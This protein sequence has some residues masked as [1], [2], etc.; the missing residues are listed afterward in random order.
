MNRLL[1][2]VNIPRFF[3]SHRLPLALA[4]RDAGYDVHVA[5]SAYDDSGY[6]ERIV[7]AGFPFHPLPLH[8]HSTSPRHELNTL[9]AITRLY[10][11]LQ[12]D[13][14]HHVTVKSILYGGIAARI[15]GVP[16]VV[17][18]VSGLGY[19]FVAS[20]AKAGVIRWGVK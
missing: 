20:G 7:E 17:N 6:M 15:S 19:V 2:L 4:A 3:V 11:R 12:P 14:V 8:Q 13:I 16:A 18:A 10:R 9:R 1:Y 5:T